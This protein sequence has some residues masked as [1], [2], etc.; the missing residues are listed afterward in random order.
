MRNDLRCERALNALYVASRSTSWPPMSTKS[1]L[2]SALGLAATTTIID[3][4]MIPVTNP[5]ATRRPRRRPSAAAS[6]SSAMM[7]S[8]SVTPSDW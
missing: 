3:S 1:A 6:S 7:I 2:R 4:T 5:H 8:P